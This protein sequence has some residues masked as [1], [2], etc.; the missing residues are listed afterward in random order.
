MYG[1]K[2][3]YAVITLLLCRSIFAETHRAY[4]PFDLEE[5]NFIGDSSNKVRIGSEGREESDTS[6]YPFTAVGYISFEDDESSYGCTGAL[7]SPNV[8]LTNGHC[9]FD[10]ATNKFYKNF[11]FSP[12]HQTSP[13]PLGEISV[14][15]IYVSTSF[16]Q[17]KVDIDY[18]FLLLEKAVGNT[19]GWFGVKTMNFSWYRTNRFYV[20][21]YGSNF[22][23]LSSIITT[24]A[25]NSHP[26]KVSRPTLLARALVHDCDTGPGNSGSP[27]FTYV[28]GLPYIVGVH[29]SGVSGDPKN[30]A[31]DASIWPGVCE[32][33]ATKSDLFLKAM[34]EIIAQ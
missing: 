6:K 25:V 11:K 19:T 16:Q 10:Q 24:Q 13:G 18:G 15:K 12:G 23:L 28:D 27:L 31:C 26:C 7:V 2:I 33:Y 21:G 30:A 4:K 29:F 9:V 3:A 32:N 22:G 5:A 8:V 34:K 20:A 1:K 17:R 14:K